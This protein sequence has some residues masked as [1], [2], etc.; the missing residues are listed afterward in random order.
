MTFKKLFLMA[1][2]VSAWSTDITGT[3]MLKGSGIDGAKLRL[4]QSG[5]RLTGEWITGSGETPLA[6]MV[7]TDS[8]EF[9]FP[10][11]RA[12]GPVE[13]WFEGTIE[14]QNSMEGTFRMGPSR[15]VSWKAKRCK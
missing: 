1:M 13:A 14:G 5:E 7:Q 11:E 4:S 6:G 15:P 12:G 8:V 2:G 10:L 3:W 9:R